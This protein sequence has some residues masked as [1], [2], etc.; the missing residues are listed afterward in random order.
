MC[1][2]VSIIS[3][4]GA[5]IDPVVLRRMG[6]TLNHRGPDAEGEYLADGV[7]FLHKR[8]SIIDLEGGQQPMAAD[9]AVLAYNGEIYNYVELR[10]DLRRQGHEFRTQSDTEVL[11]RSYL[12]H[13]RQSLLEMNGMFAFVLHDS[14]R[15]KVLAA[16]DHFG[17]KPLYYCVTD[18]FILFASEIKALL[19][20]PDVTARV[21]HDALQDYLTFQY[22][23]DDATLFAG[24]QKIGAGELL[25]VDLDRGEFYTERYWQPSFKVDEHH[26]EMYFVEHLRWLLEDTVNQQLRSD[27]PLGTYLSGGMDS[28]LVTSLASR[29]YPDRLRCFNGAFAEG[30]DFD[31]SQ[32]ARDVCDQIGAE[33]MMVHPTQDEFI[34]LFPKLIYHMDEPAAGPGLFPQYMVSRLA[35]ENVKVCLGGQ[36]GDEIFGGY[37]RYVIA[38]L[39]QALKG[40]LM[41]TTEEGEHIV[42][43]ASILPNLPYVQRYVPMLRHFWSD[44]L[45]EDMDRRY[46]RLIDRSGGTVELFS[47]DFRAAFDREAVFGRFQTVFNHPDTRSYFNKMTH[48]D[49][50]T[51]LPSLLHVEDRVS[52]AHSLE[53]RVPLLDRRIAETVASMPPA[54][55]FKGGEMKHILKRTATDL[56]P[57]SVLERKDKMGFPVPLHLWAR[58]RAGDFFRDILLSSACRERGLFDRKAVEDLVNRE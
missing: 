15:R 37:A 35:A 53:S 8:L 36:G 28:S 52:M 16:R 40:A 30:R 54:M 7:G 12:A 14:R 11:L 9:G 58:G 23:L 10:E 21:D 26:T 19:Q 34:D 32:F 48:Y 18:D 29:R 39:E 44:G 24:I 43:L 55:K 5:P 4:R 38:Y 50:L 47:D 33:L 13:G 41:E 17:I 46:F 42:S 2:F 6:D 45:F 1:G 56:L 22:V 20:H 3:R 57:T 27:V 49:M 31:E 51:G 25:E